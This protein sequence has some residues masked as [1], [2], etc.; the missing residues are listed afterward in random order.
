MAASERRSRE[1]FRGAAQDSLA[2]NGEQVN[3]WMLET[4]GC[5]PAPRTGSKRL[6]TGGQMCREENHVRHDQGVFIQTSV[7]SSPAVRALATGGRQ[8][9]HTWSIEKEVPPLEESQGPTLLKGT[10]AML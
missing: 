10:W 4:S 8:I 3:A 6:N 5:P 2:D 1:S 7:R 9:P